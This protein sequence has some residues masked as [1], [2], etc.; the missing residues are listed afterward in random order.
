MR[1][2]IIGSGIAGNAA[3][4]ALSYASP[5][6]RLAVYERGRLPGGHSATEQ[7]DY[8]GKR[9][10]VDT[11]FIVY[12]EPN[13]PQLTAMF[14][15]LGVA[16]EQ[17]DMSF[18]VSAEN[19]RFEWSGGERGKFNSFFA[20]RRNIVSPAHWRLLSEIVLF[21]KT[22][23]ADIA[24]G[25]I[26]GGTLG[27]YLDRHGYSARLRQSYIL[28]MGAAIWSMPQAAM[29][30]FPAATLIGFFDNHGLLTWQGHKWRTVSGGSQVYVD[31]LTAPFRSALRLGVA[32][33]AVRR[34]NNGVTIIDSSGDT[35]HFDHVIMA[36]HAP[37][38]L[39]LLTDASPRERAILGAVKTSPNAV[40]LHRDARLMPR[41]KAAWA[42]WN[43]LQAQASAGR[44]ISVTYWM[45]RLQN[46]DP[47]CPLFV[48][49][50]PP[51]EPDPSLTFARYTYDHPQFNAP[52]LAA[53]NSLESIQGG[54]HTWFCG[55]WTRYGFHED[56]LRSGLAV[57]AA[58]GAQAPWAAVP[59]FA[60]QAAE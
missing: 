58:L 1:I 60:A 15:H 33:V 21:Q 55:A 12:N 31:K 25:T 51:R 41:R 52:A 49:L 32:A 44:Q 13:Y 29:L 6:A 36:A 24:A 30:D 38:S 19:G 23:R 40:F 20:Q 4:Y 2:A 34:G 35:D 54:R 48:S 57:A 47:R 5:S 37:Q 46:L 10:S 26:G 27:D 28:P 14:D 39:A 53:Q 22:A 56:G 11:G 45:N 17:S 8:D 50:N 7:I 43:V 9:I 18:A 42:S 16:T 59:A 3:A